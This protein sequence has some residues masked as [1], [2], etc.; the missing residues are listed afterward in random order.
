MF[1]KRLGEGHELKMWICGCV[2]S[3]ALCDF[4]H[5]ELTSE[6]ESNKYFLNVWRARH[7]PQSVHLFFVDKTC[8]R[9][10]YS[11]RVPVWLS[12]KAFGLKAEGPRF[13][14]ASV[15]YHSS[16]VVV[17]GHCLVILSLTVNETLKRL[18]SLPISMQNSFGW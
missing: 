8:F 9:E 5:T 6:K 11:F 18:S 14:S 2:A 16:N 17:C 7:Q 4:R 13:D 10:A 3:A 15:S 1:T 12:G